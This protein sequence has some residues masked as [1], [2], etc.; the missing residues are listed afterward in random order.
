MM[1]D[2]ILIDASVR[3]DAAAGRRAEFERAA[4]AADPARGFADALVRPG[5]AVV[6]E[7]KRRSP[8]SRP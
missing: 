1:L 5:L 6:A 2:R 7:V 8:S 3:S 4:A